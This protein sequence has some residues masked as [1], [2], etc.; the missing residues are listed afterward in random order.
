MVS[1]SVL[2]GGIWGHIRAMWLKDTVQRR[3]VPLGVKNFLSDD[4][5]GAE[6]IREKENTVERSRNAGKNGSGKGALGCQCVRIRLGGCGNGKR[7]VLQITAA[8]LSESVQSCWRHNCGDPDK[9]AKPL[10]VL[11]GRKQHW[12]KKSEKSWEILGIA[13]QYCMQFVGGDTME[14]A[15]GLTKRLDFENEEKMKYAHYLKDCGT[16]PEER[17]RSIVG[18]VADRNNNRIVESTLPFTNSAL[19]VCENGTGYLKFLESCGR[20]TIHCT[21]MMRSR[22]RRAA[23]GRLNH[24]RIS[25]CK[26]AAGLSGG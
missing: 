5:S 4:C 17:D 9:M 7:G 18:K 22:L 15:P 11:E 26:T 14:T 20:R 19:L 8:W 6:W 13:G 25:W 1:R 10:G 16:S 21:K 2:V 12:S 24:L 3:E 23:V